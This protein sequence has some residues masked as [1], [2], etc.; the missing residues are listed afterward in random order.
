[1][2]IPVGG[3][4][5]RLLGSGWHQGRGANDEGENK[6]RWVVTAMALNRHTERVLR[7]RSRLHRIRADL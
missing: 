1:M 2:D 4:D 7:E 5:L 3:Y 6:Q